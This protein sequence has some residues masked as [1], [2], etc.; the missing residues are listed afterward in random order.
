[1]KT[2][3][4]QIPDIAKFYFIMKIEALQICMEKPSI[5]LTITSIFVVVVV[6]AAVVVNSIAITIN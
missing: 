2:S 1:M 6:A 4:L 5:N 3:Y